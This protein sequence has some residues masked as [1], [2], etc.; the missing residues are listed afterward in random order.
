MEI[1]LTSE[2]FEQGTLS[3]TSGVSLA[4]NK[5]GGDNWVCTKELIPCLSDRKIHIS[6]NPS[7]LDVRIDEYN[8]EMKCIKT[9]GWHTLGWSWDLS[10]DAAYIAIVMAIPGGQSITRPFMVD[11]LSRIPYHDDWISIGVDRWRGAC[12]T[13]TTKPYTDWGIKAGDVVT[14]QVR[15]K[16]TSGKKLRARIEWFNSNDDRIP[17]FPDGAQVIEN[18]EGVSTITQTVPSGYSQMGLWIDANLTVATHTATTQE[19][20]KAD[21]FVIGSSIPS[22]L[23]R[24]GVLTMSNYPDLPI[25]TDESGFE[26][27]EGM[28]LWK[29]SGTETFDGALGTWSRELKDDTSV[30]SGKYARCTLSVKSAQF[31]QWGVYGVGTKYREY[32]VKNAPMTLS[33]YARASREISFSM[34]VEFAGKGIPISLTTQWQ[35]I[36][37]SVVCIRTPEDS[38]S[39]AVCFYSPNL[40]VGDYIDLS[41]PMLTYGKKFHPYRPNPADLVGGGVPMAIV[42]RGLPLTVRNSI[43]EAIQNSAA[44]L[45]QRLSTAITQTGESIENKVAQQYYAKGDTDRLIAEA[46]TIL[47]QKYNSFEMSFNSFKQVVNNNQNLTN[48][49]F[50]TITKFIRFIDGNIFLGEEGNNQMLKIAKDRISFLQG[51]QEVAYISDSTL[52]IYDGV[53]LN[54]LRIGDFAFV[55][56]ANGSM[57]LKKVR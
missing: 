56:R 26:Y 24:G 50:A 17:T 6:G 16:S 2:M 20:V 13:W 37:A 53:F 31:P 52:Y 28:N 42:A 22:N 8:K 23:D 39:I 38:S 48:A 41:S 36:E 43:D 32:F 5:L 9:A 11:T 21:I 12:S 14:F 47:E 46:S 57:D 44:Q 40:N 10:F 19:L 34:G 45:E 3:A 29:G 51:N 55:P 1:K 15:I 54:S 33:L 7:G 35:K 49:E 25:V 27:A 30:P 4:Q 18:G